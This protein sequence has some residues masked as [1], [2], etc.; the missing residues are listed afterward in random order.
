MPTF[1]KDLWNENDVAAFGGD[2][3]ETLRYRSNLLGADLRITNFGGGNTSSKYEVPDPL[4]G[5][6]VKVM[7]VKGSGGDL[8]SIKTTGFAVLYMDRLVGLEKVY[9]GEAF[10]DEMVGLYPSCSF[11]GNT[12]ATSIDTPLHGFLPFDH[13]DHLHPDWA[14]AIAASR[15]GKEKM[16]EFNARY[17]HKLVW[18]PWQRPG[19]ELGLM[20]RKAVEDNPG[21]DGIVLASHGLFTWGATQRESYWNSVTIIDQMGEFV[22]GHGEG[23]TLFGGPLTA[24]R[25]DRGEVAVKIMPKVRGKVSQ[26][27]RWIGHFDDS[28][29]ALEFMNSQHGRALAALGTSCPDHFLRTRIAPLLVDWNPQTQDLGALDAALES[30]LVAYRETYTRYYETNKE[31]GSPGLRDQNPTV[32]LVPGVGMISFGRSK[33]EARITGEFF[34]NAIRVMAGASSMGNGNGAGGPLPHAKDPARA[35][36]FTSLYNYVALP[37]KEAFRIE[38]W[39]LEEAKLKRMPPEKE[40]SRRIILVVGGGSGIGRCT[41]LKLAEGGA[42]LMLADINEDAAAGVAGECARIAG[43][44]AVASCRLDLRDQAS[45]AAAIEKTVAQFGGLDGVINTAAVFIPPDADGNIPVEHWRLTMD[46]NVTGNYLLAKEAQKVFTA[47]GLPSVIVLTSSANAVV[48]KKGSEAYDVSKTAVNHLIGELAVG[49]APLVRV[50]GIAPATV[51]AGSTMFPRDRVISSLKKYNLPFKDE[52]SDDQL[53]DRLAEFYAS[54]TLL[55]TPILPDHCAEA[56][57]FL[58]SDRSGR[59]S[60]NVIPVD[61]GLAEAFLR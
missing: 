24:S 58:T 44:E 13:V 29:E 19:F 54:R 53:R 3:L 51:V 2:Q 43:K 27:R 20:L 50:N 21:C 56:I 1:L 47:Q 32:V 61:G 26:K 60:G 31:P 12:V 52:D 16:E 34:R 39:Q 48:P 7:A 4:S 41:A 23:K 59:T 15:N 30:G 33:T 35:A 46:V 22:L 18:L 49:M 37:P 42:H 9:K 38:Y 55:K 8:G 14:I 17:G 5:R 25:E 36:E 11:A 45:M 57:V 10:E 6:P 40:F 28:P